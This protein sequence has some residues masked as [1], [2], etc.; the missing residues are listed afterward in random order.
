MHILKAVGCLA[1]VGMHYPLV[2]EIELVSYRLFKAG[3]RDIKGWK[4]KPR[5]RNPLPLCSASE[6]NE[7]GV[8]RMAR[9]DVAACPIP[10]RRARNGL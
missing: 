1:L 7:P 6:A 3:A 5:D 10:S 9:K 4:S 8:A 2:A